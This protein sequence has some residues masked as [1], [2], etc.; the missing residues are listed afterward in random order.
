MEN[1]STVYSELFSE[2]NTTENIIQVKYL[3]IFILA[4]INK[5]GGLS[6]CIPIDVKISIPK[7][8]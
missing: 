6:K 2:K 1:T 3:N 7:Y 8:P 5:S 4:N